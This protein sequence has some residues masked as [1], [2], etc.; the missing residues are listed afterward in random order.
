M[1]LAQIP[2]KNIRQ[3]L[4]SPTMNRKD[5]RVAVKTDLC[6]DDVDKGGEGASEVG[7]FTGYSA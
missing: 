7:E 2:G 4:F 3:A 1:C 5:T 6:E